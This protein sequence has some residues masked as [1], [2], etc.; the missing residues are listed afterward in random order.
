MSDL[1]ELFAR[2]PRDLTRAD[3]EEIVK[4]FRERRHLFTAGNMSAGKTKTVKV[5]QSKVVDLGGLDL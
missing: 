4:G 2:D 3:I 5:D 1:A